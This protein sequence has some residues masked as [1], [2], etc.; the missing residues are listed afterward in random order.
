MANAAVMMT[1]SVMPMATQ[2][3]RARREEKD[4]GPGAGEEFERGNAV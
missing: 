2:G 1:I 3:A 4:V